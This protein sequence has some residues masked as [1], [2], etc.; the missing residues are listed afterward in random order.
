MA[1][2]RIMYV[3]A[4]VMGVAL[5]TSADACER[6]QAID[7]FPA[8]VPAEATCIPYLA[9]NGAN[10]TSCHWSFPLRERGAKELAAD[11][12]AEV[13]RCR[14]G[15][16]G[17]TDTPV[18]HPDSFDLLEWRANNAIYRVSVKDK[19][20]LGQTLVFLSREDP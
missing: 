18:N 8:T 1:A 19:G 14:P 2:M 12:W 10:G 15:K 16:A 9:Q 3:K 13:Q 7:A 6:L 20:G 11:L 17:D 5:H 4:V